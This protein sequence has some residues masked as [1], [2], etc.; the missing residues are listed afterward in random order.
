MDNYYIIYAVV[1][2]FGTIKDKNT[3]KI[4]DWRGTRFLVQEFEVRDGK[5]VGAQSK[6][7]KANKDCGYKIGEKVDLLFDAN[8]KV[9]KVVCLK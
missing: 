3:G 6:Y 4:N 1:E 9:K 5:T 7:M 8:G 2:D